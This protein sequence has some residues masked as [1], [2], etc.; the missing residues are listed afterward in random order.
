M[1]CPVKSLSEGSWPKLAEGFTHGAGGNGKRRGGDLKQL[2]R[3]I[4][5]E[6]EITALDRIHMSG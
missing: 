2:V 3:F 1:S 5:D 4:F 6:G